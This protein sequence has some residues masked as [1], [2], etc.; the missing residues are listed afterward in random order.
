[1]TEETTIKKTFVQGLLTPQTILY[2]FGAMV[3]VV[4]FWTK[5]ETSWEKE[6]A[7][8]ERVGRQY[9]SMNKLSERITSLEKQSEYQRGLDDGKKQIK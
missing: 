7:L 1:M 4:V 9:E 8:E 6:K 2:L 5:T 3:A